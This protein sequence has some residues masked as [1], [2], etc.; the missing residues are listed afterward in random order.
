MGFSRI[1]AC[2]AIRRFSIAACVPAY[3]KRHGRD[4]VSDAIYETIVLA[5]VSFLRA[6]EHLAVG[7]QQR[8]FK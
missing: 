2:S 7:K 3:V 8:R 1:I 6:Q 4:L 5:I